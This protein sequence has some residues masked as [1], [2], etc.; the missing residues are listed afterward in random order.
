MH[1]TLQEIM[2]TCPDWDKF[3]ALKGVSEWAVKEGGGDVQITLNVQEAHQLGIVK[4]PDW[5]IRPTL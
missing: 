2:D 5:K 3:C 1:M 4:L